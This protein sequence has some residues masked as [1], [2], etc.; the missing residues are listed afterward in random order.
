[1]RFNFLNFVFKSF[2]SFIVGVFEDRRG[3]ADG[4]LDPL[5]VVVGFALGLGHKLEEGI[6]DG[7]KLCA[8]Q[9]GVAF[10]KLAKIASRKS[11][12]FLSRVVEQSNP[13]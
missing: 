4:H 1:M 12:Q 9:L 7:V 5:L 6:L 8:K 2:Q 10:K 11:N 3:I 13:L